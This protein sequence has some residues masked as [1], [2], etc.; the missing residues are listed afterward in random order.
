MFDD[1]TERLIARYVTGDCSAAEAE[2]VRAWAAVV[3]ARARYLDELEQSWRAAGAAP[4][5]WDS[6]AGW[7]AVRDRLAGPRPA[8]RPALAATGSAWTRRLAAAG[9]VIAAAALTFRVFAPGAHH[10]P[11][12]PMRTV[13]TRRGELADVYL[14]DGTRVRLGTMS[15][16]RF[17]SPL[18]A[19]ERDVY[20][21]GEAL[22][23]VAHD[24]LAPFT[25]RTRQ[26]TARDLGTRFDVAAYP[27]DSTMTVAV[28]EGRVLVAAP[29]EAASCG[30]GSASAVLGAGDLGRLDGGA[31][32]RVHRG[33]S[34]ARYLAWTD[35]RLVFENAPLREVLP[36]LGRWYD[37][38]FRLADSAL[39]GRR[40][41]ATLTS[42]SLP[43]L[44]R[45]LSLAIDVRIRQRGRVV[46]LSPAGPAR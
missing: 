46:T 16:L 15:T 41:T 39:A 38:D 17:A 45:E 11:P 42:Q 32:V 20:L 23:D 14:S 21:E 12:A 31:C 2:A 35:H 6:A 25:V 10:R 8:H 4:Q 33:A 19:R 26:G 27:L 40:L 28:A 7:A 13:T 1:A 24:S 43:E 36:S 44:M 22:F 18:G 9:I 5:Q 30:D 34:I 37:V 3:P 29:H